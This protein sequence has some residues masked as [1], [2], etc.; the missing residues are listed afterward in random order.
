MICWPGSRQ[1]RRFLNLRNPVSHSHF[2]R[3]HLL[4]LRW[5]LIIDGDHSINANV[6]RFLAGFYANSATM[7][8]HATDPDIFRKYLSAAATEIR[9]QSQA[10]SAI[11]L[12]IELSTSRSPFSLFDAQA[13]F[14][15]IRR[16]CS[17]LSDDSACH[18][19]MVP[20][21]FQSDESGSCRA[22]VDNG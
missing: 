14:P 22:E 16:R 3:C 4:N 1:A 21:D 17:H 9:N 8:C 20:R 18:T 19:N 11:A 7:D 10:D 2:L 6:F 13:F 12:H 15:L 5:D